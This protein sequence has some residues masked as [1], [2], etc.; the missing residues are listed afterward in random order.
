[1]QSTKSSSLQS[2]LWCGAALA[3]LMVAGGAQAATAPAA[4]APAD[5]ATP[6]DT[7]STN[8]E[9]IVITGQRETRSAVA[10]QSE[11]IQRVLPGASPLKAIQFLPGV[12]YR[13]YGNYNGLSVSRAVTSEN[14][15]RVTLSS[16]AGSLGVASTSNLGGAIETYS[17]DPSAQRGLNLRQ[18]LGS[19]E[20]T[21]TFVRADSG[22]LGNG[23]KG[24]VS[25]V[26]QDAK[27]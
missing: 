21:R 23:W 11:Q 18:T 25:Y 13:A 22:D 26:Y 1:M 17:R 5:A 9:Q 6:S 15:S 20:A 8:V 14:V 4:P 3:A 2:R 16:G 19:Y 27:A 24:F 10:M 7:D 12:I